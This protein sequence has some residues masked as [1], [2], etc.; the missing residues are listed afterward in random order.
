MLD[1]QGSALNAVVLN[2]TRFT[3]MLGKL[4]MVEE[5]IGRVRAPDIHELVKAYDAESGFTVLR[6]C[7]ASGQDRTESREM[8][9]REDYPE[10]NDEEWFCWHTLQLSAH[11]IVFGKQRIPIER[12]PFKPPSR[13]RQY[14]PIA[15]IM[16][17]AH[18][19]TDYH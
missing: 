14:S 4:D 7:L 16:Q 10:T 12:F 17:G 5:M 18:D 8:F 9:Y 11:G 15:A 13:P 19:S 1:I 2:G 6:L 3:E